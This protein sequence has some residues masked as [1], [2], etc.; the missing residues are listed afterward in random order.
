MVVAVLGVAVR[1]VWM[2]KWCISSRVCIVV[3]LYVCISD[4][5]SVLFV[6]CLFVCDKCNKFR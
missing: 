1:V 5:P 6:A 4:E 3:V 2:C